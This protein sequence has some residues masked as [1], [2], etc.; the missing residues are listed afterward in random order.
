MSPEELVIFLREY[1]G[2]MSNIIMDE[3]GLIDKYE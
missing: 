3:R 1:L 2:A